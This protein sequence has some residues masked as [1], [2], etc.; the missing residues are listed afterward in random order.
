MDTLRRERLVGGLVEAY[1]DWRESCTRVDDAYRSWARDTDPRD[2]V[3]YG[4][5]MA[6]LDAE[7]Q[8]ADIYA[9]LVRRACRLPWSDDPPAEALGGPE[10][11][12]DWA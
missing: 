1:V 12:F 8:A 11:G 9:G 5:Y 4:L 7:Q 10:A 6:A 2:G 3:A